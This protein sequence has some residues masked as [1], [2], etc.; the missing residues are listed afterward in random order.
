A[1]EHG[2]VAMYCGGIMQFA[3]IKVPCFNVEC[4]VYHCIS[5]NIFLTVIY[6]PPTYPMTLFKQNIIK[7]LQWLEHI[8]KNIIV[9]GDFNDDILKSSSICTFFKDRGYDQ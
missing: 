6:R 4:L 5:L 1:K 3:I 9:M 7:L 8:G 2:G